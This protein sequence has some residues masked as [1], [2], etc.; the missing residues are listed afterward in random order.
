M[1]LLSTGNTAWVL[2][3]T[4]MVLMMSIPGIIFFYGGLSKRKNVLNTMFLSLIAFAIASIIWIAFGYQ[5][6]FSSSTFM[7]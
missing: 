7:G 4:I 3:S 1:T 2:I 6:S 5:T